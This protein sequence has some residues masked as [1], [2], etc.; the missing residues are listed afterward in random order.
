M[1][2]TA[3]R[4]AHSSRIGRHHSASSGRFTGS[5]INTPEDAV[6]DGDEDQSSLRIWVERPNRYREEQREGGEVDL[7]IRDGELWWTYD[8]LFG[9]STNTT[10]AEPWQSSVR[11]GYEGLVDPARLAAVL[12]FEPLD[13]GERARRGVLRA[14]AVA[15]KGDAPSRDAALMSIGGAGADEYQL[16][17]D[18][19]R[20]VVLYAEARLGGS[21]FSVIEAEA[22]AFDEAIEADTF[23]FVSPG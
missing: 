17:I 18:A 8:A 16:E 10:D 15:R 4:R 21:A 12:T 1:A 19:A 22:V 2:A 13:H 3:E 6:S 11:G 5:F 9:A 20:G 23:V 14:R 7:I